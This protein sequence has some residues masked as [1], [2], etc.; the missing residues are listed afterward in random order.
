MFDIPTDVYNIETLSFMTVFDQ[1]D[2][3]RLKPRFLASHCK[4]CLAPAV[5]LGL[6]LRQVASSPKLNLV[7]HK[8]DFLFMSLSIIGIKLNIIQ[9]L[10]N[11]NLQT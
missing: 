10:N 5:I 4:L 7:I 11:A 3:H 9:P 8:Y 6:A 2:E 1:P